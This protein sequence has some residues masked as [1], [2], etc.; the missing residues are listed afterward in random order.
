MSLLVVQLPSHRQLAASAEEAAAGRGV[1]GW[2]H[3]Y[4]ADGQVAGPLTQAAAHSW[5]KATEVVLVLAAADTSWHLIRLPRAPASRLREALAGAMEDLLLDDSDSVHL[6]IAPG[7]QP[8]LPAWVL[9]TNGR[10][11]KTALS[12]LAAAGIKAHRLV[13]ALPPPGGSLRAHFFLPAQP[14]TSRA[15]A[16][17]P[18]TATGPVLTVSHATGAWSLPL[19]RPGVDRNTASATSLAVA[20]RDELPSAATADARWTTTPQAAGAARRFMA[21]AV[22]IQTDAEH[23]LERALAPLN[24]LQFDLAPRHPGFTAFASATQALRGP[25]WRALRIGLAALLG[26]HLMGLNAYAA[27]QRHDLQTL[28]QAQTDLLRGSFAGVRS[29]LDAP[30]QMASETQRLRLGAGRPGPGDLESALAA[31]AAAWPNGKPPVLQLQYESGRLSLEA[32]N[33]RDDERAAFSAPLQAAG[34]QVTHTA[35]EITMVYRAPP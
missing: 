11:L 23:L 22:H 28:R 34:W 16:H 3:T 35:G 1:D 14:G 20:W 30:A 8:G 29:V 21:Q 17:V 25:Q 4:S 18:S 31:A 32:A 13:P 10:Q 9:A 27:K 7:A 15:N 6:A 26:L 24:L 12:A 2:W 5:P 33:W 19:P